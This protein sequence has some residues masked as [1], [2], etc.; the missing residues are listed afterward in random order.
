MVIFV[1][2]FF[3]IY[4]LE[5][6][7]YIATEIEVNWLPATR[8]LG[9][10][11]KGISELRLAEYQHIVANSPEE[12]DALAKG[13]DDKIRHIQDKQAVYEPLIVTPEE[14]DI[15]AAFCQK[16][17]TYLTENRK[18][19]SLSSQNQKTEALSLL[20]DR[21]ETTFSEMNLDLG[22]LIDINEKGG[23]DTSNRGDSILALSSL[24]LIALGVF[25]LIVG[26]II[27]I[28]MT[29]FLITNVSVT[30]KYQFISE[31]R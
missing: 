19:V 17:K 9:D 30:R 7:N 28:F 8:I 15:Y 12:M 13:I 22:N 5:R 29:Y 26:L 27:C 6:V 31:K 10:I 24:Q 4:Q 1:L 16:W 18:I 3:S 14:K 20:H 2:V 11:N 25:A 21:S 23:I